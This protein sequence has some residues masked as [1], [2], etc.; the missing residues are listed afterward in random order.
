MPRSFSASLA[1][2]LLVL[3]LA[4]GF[5]TAQVQ[6]D[7]TY[8]LTATSI[9]WQV[10]GFT[11]TYEGTGPDPKFDI[12]LLVL[13]SFSGVDCMQPDDGNSQTFESRYW[14]TDLLSVPAGSS[15]SPLTDGVSNVWKFGRAGTPADVIMLPSYWTYEQHAVPLPPSVFL[16]GAGLIGL[17]VARRKNRLG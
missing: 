9:N 10:S 8:L 11:L 16:L 14:F 4:I 5:G 13:G 12:G 3:F 17:A 6:A 2:V 1:C 7:T 15:S